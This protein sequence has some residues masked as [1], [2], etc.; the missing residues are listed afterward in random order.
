MQAMNLHAKPSGGT[1]VS[2]RPQGQQAA[3]RE[4]ALR[5]GMGF[6]ALPPWRLCRHTDAR[7]HAALADA[8]QAATVVFT[9]PAA[10]AAAASLGELLQRAPQRPWLAVGE[11][12][13]QALLAAGHVH[14]QAPQRMDSEGLLALPTLQNVAGTRVGLVTAP[15]G[16]G[17][18][19]AELQQRGATLVRADVY[20]RRPLPLPPR[21]LARLSRA[22]TPWR[23]L[24]SSGEALQRV[25]A[26]LDP[27]WQA[28][29]RQQM[30]V[31]AASA[32]L[33]AQAHALGLTDSVVADGPGA[34]ALMAA[35]HTLARRSRTD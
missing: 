26:A 17:M 5:D 1:V 20:Q 18:L 7:A 4:Q 32:R 34:D 27:G 22:A 10:V 16:R 8:L 19:V 30:Q 3:V 6:V 25:W 21:A 14:V 35:V 9:S 11:G 2:L 24:L 15:G 13:R 33:Q 12:T 23:L 29:W 28:R 31:V